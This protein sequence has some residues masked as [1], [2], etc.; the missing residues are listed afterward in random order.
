MAR[1]LATAGLP[2][3]VQPLV[4]AFNACLQ[5]MEEAHTR[6]VSFMADA[7]HELKTPLMLLRAQLELGD[8]DPQALLTDVDQLS[9]QVQQWLVLAEVTERA[10]EQVPQSGAAQGTNEVGRALAARA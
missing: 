4:V 8:A 3:E 7:A 10:G 9:R 1:R 6:H 5:R 2:Q